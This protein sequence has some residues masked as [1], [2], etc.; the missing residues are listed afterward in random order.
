MRRR[1]LTA[2][3]Q[4]IGDV[5]SIWR[6]VALVVAIVV[7]I[8]ALAG[9]LGKQPWSALDDRLGLFF[10]I[11]VDIQVLLGLIA[12]LIGPFNV[13]QMSGA[14]GNPLLRFYLVEHPLFGLIAVALAHIGRRRSR[15]AQ[16]DVQ[17]H[18]G[19]FIYYLLSFLFIV[20]IF[21]MRTRLG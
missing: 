17:K 16:P 11:A 8:K 13:T 4:F 21:V 19:A 2:I 14:M 3:G 10:T 6:W 5:H 7:V 12:W 15:R 18:R 1:I 20:L 9:W